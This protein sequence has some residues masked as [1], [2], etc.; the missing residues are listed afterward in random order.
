VYEI[1]ITDYFKKKY[2]KL[3]LLLLDIGGH[4]GGTGVY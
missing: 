4:S 3:V 2:K 1:E